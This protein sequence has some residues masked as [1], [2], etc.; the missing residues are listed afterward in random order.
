MAQTTTIYLSEEIPQDNNNLKPLS[1]F[2]KN[3]TDKPAILHQ[4]PLSFRIVIWNKTSLFNTIMS[5]K[6]TTSNSRLQLIA[7][8]RMEDHEPQKGK[9]PSG[10]KADA[11]CGIKDS[12]DLFNV[13]SELVY[14]ST[15]EQNVILSGEGERQINE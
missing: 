1:L 13:Q 5:T 4:K 14:R 3:R 8:Q 12:I 15:I 7:Q 2:F 10:G 11:R 6:P 9:K